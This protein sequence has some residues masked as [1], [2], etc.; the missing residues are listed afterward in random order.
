M[1]TLITQGS[2]HISQHVAHAVHHSPRFRTYTTLPRTCALTFKPTHVCLRRFSCGK[3]KKVRT[4]V[5]RRDH[6]RVMTRLC[7]S[8]TEPECA[9]RRREMK[10]KHTGYT[11]G[12]YQNIFPRTVDLGTMRVF[13]ANIALCCYVGAGPEL[14]V[15]SVC[16]F[17]D[18]LH[19]NVHFSPIPLSPHILPNLKQIS[20]IWVS[21]TKPDQLFF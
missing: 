13:G 2:P 5:S 8:F 10:S 11:E 18:P 16:T 15:L 19:A 20:S 6:F 17:C 1:R 12:R 9:H 4:C 21:Q 3:E 7:F 14:G